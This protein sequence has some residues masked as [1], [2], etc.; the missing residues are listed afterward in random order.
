MATIAEILDAIIRESP[1]LEEGLAE[2]IINLSALSRKLLPQVQAALNKP[3][4]ESAILMALKRMSPK[5]TQR[6]ELNTHSNYPVGDITVRSDLS[7]FT[8]LRSSNILEKQK[9][10][11]NAIKDKMNHFITFTQGVFEI[12][13]IIDSNLESAVE[14]IFEGEKIMSRL[15]DLAAITI[16]LYPQTVHTTGVYYSIL[17]Q[18]AWHDVNVVEVVSTYTE[19]TIILKKEKIDASFSILMNFLSRKNESLSQ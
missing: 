17:K 18:L 2:G 14:K 4:S 8:F 15:K 16:R 11:L 3:V 7:E 10:L 1:F 9:E 19:F 13:A 5:I 6:M 12:T